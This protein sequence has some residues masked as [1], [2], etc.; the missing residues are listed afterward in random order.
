MTARMEAAQMALRLGL[1]ASGRRGRKGVFV[2]CEGLERL[3]QSILATRASRSLEVTNFEVDFWLCVLSLKEEKKKMDSTLSQDDFDHTP[4]RWSS[5]KTMTIRGSRLDGVLPPLLRI[6]YL[7]PPT[8]PSP[9]APPLIH[10]IH[11]LP[12]IPVSPH[13]RTHWF[14]IS[15]S[16]NRN[17]QKHNSKVPTADSRNDSPTRANQPAIM[18]PKPSSPGSNMDVEQRAMDLLDVPFSHFFPGETDADDP[19]IRERAKR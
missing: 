16:P 8:F 19:C 4:H 6:S 11:A 3:F 12:V 1:G 7:L 13:L 5:L 18:N 10:V 15:F 2:P 14:S 9:T 17:G